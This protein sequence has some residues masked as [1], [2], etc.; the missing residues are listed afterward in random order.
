MDLSSSQIDN[1]NNNNNNNSKSDCDNDVNPVHNSDLDVQNHNP[2]EL[3][4][5]DSSDFEDACSDNDPDES[6][7]KL[8]TINIP[9]EKTL[10]E[11]N[12]DSCDEI[13]IP[14]IPN[15]CHSNEKQTDIHNEQI[16]NTSNSSKQPDDCL[17]EQK[18]DEKEGEKEEEEKL[19]VDMNNDNAEAEEPIFDFLGKSNEIVCITN[20]VHLIQSLP[21][22]ANM[23]HQVYKKRLIFGI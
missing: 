17:E 9:E 23:Y 8:K 18:D 16:D 5:I 2:T 20:A 13:S 4:D 19:T 7:E 1:Q 11:L 3:F 10:E 15:E 22:I 12:G 6:N 14:T 21:L